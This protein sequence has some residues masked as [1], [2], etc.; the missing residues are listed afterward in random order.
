MTRTELALAD[1]LLA[2]VRTAGIVDVGELAHDPQ[3]ALAADDSVH[4]RWVDPQSL[5]PGCS[6]AAMYDPS[7]TPATISVASDASAGRRRFSLLHEYAH[8][9][10]NQS[11]EVVRALFSSPEPT[12]LEERMCDAFAG[13][14]LIPEHARQRAFSAGV[15][16]AAVVELMNDSAASAQAVAVAAAEAMEHPG[17]VVLLNGA[18]EADFAARAGDVY[19]LKRGASQGGL[20]ANAARGVVVRGVAAL[21][22]GGGNCT[23]ELNVETAVGSTCVVAV[24][25]DGPAPWAKLSVGRTTSVASREAWCDNC[26]SAFTSYKPACD[27]CG[28]PHCPVCN[29]CSCEPAQVAGER[30]CTACF[31]VQPPAAFAGP[32]ASV[33]QDCA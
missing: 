25:V 14:V 31:I 1:L 33:C 21:H 2:H 6:I 4:V 28:E 18:G 11:R 7:T 5:P 17:Y 13:R 32:T 27:E 10:R 8:H 23:H 15:T 30:M 9:L 16:A 24:M 20:L 29:A 22:L 12:A 3:R 26:T 19:P